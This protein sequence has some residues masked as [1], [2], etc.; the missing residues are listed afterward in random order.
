M[1]GDQCRRTPACQPNLPLPLLSS[2]IQLGSPVALLGHLLS[3]QS[4]A[5]PI[6]LLKGVFGGSS[7]KGANC[8]LEFGVQIWCPRPRKLVKIGKL[9]GK[10]EGINGVAYA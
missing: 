2:R 9:G 3:R 5:L 1:M 7:S 10:W 4:P 8:R 6:S